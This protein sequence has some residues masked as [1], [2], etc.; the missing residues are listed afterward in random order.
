MYLD[1]KQIDCNFALH[2]K[3][4]CWLQLLVVITL[5]LIHLLLYMAFPRGE[6]V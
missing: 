1:N 4:K 3:S 2:F 6:N 5:L